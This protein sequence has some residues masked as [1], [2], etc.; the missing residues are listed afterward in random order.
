MPVVREYAAVAV[1]FVPHSRTLLVVSCEYRA[2]TR[3]A[4]PYV[5]SEKPF[6]IFCPLGYDYNGVAKVVDL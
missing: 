2:F 5:A 4:N 3:E 6:G 1:L